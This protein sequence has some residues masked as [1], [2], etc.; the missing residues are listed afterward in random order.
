MYSKAL[1]CTFFGK[2]KT[3]AAQNLCNFCYLIE[4]RQEDQ[5][6]VLLK[7]FTMQICSTQIVL[8][9]IQKPAPARSVQ[10]EAVYLEALL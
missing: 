2:E 8:D 9:P 6:T 3:R 4:W 10:L 7:V 1:R 5:K